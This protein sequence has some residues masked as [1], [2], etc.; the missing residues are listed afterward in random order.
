M[1]F[2]KC[3]CMSW[4][5]SL[6]WN[7]KVLFERHA[8]SVICRL[9]PYHFCCTSFLR[10]FTRDRFLVRL[11]DIYEKLGMPYGCQFEQEHMFYYK[12]EAF[13]GD[14][15]TGLWEAAETERVVCVCA[16]LSFDVYEKYRRWWA[17]PNVIAFARRFGI[18]MPIP[19]GS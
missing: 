3:G 5:G 11:L 17:S 15:A 8:L 10:E 18:D 2:S 16:G 6:H 1:L 14:R 19:L 12:A 7:T 9:V 13:V 4:C